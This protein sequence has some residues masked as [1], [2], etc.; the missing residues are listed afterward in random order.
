MW[1]NIINRIII[2]ILIRV[3]LQRLL[4][5]TTNGRALGPAAEDG[6]VVPD[7]EPGQAGGAVVVAA[8]ILSGVDDSTL[9]VAAGDAA[10]G[11]VI[12]AGHQITCAVGHPHNRSLPV[13]QVGVDLAR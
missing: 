9:H 11:I 3:G 1:I 6:I 7:T 13:E 4:Q 8:G 2:G 5:G 10:E 12:V